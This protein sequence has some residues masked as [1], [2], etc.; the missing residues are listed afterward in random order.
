[1]VTNFSEVWSELSGHGEIIPCSRV[2]VTVIR[3][4]NRTGTS[5]IPC[6]HPTPQEIRLVP[7]RDLHQAAAVLVAA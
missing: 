7:N 5:S 3:A 4:D 1:M 6:R 2:V